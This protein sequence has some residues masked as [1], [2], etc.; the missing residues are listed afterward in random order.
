[1]TAFLAGYAGTRA[2]LDALYA[3]ADTPLTDGILVFRPGD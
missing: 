1:M 3:V 2:T